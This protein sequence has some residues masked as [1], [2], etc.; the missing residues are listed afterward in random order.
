MSI[1]RSFAVFPA[2]WLLAT[3]YWLLFFLPQASSSELRTL[4]GKVLT[5]ELVGLT[6]KEVVL[7]GASGRSTTP[8]NE[9]LLVDLQREM[10]PPSGKYSDVELIDGSLFH[11]SRLNIKGSQVELKFGTPELTVTLPLAAVAYVLNS[12]DDSSS[13]PDWD[14]LIAKKSSQ[15]VL[16]IKR[17]GVLNGVEGTLGEVN[18]KGEI[19]FEYQVGEARKSRPMD[20][21]RIH[22]MIFQRSPSPDPP[23]PLC[24][25]QDVNQNLLIAAKIELADQTL[26]V[27]LVS[28]PKIRLPRAS[29]SRLDFNNDKVVF[30][31]DLKPVE[32]IEKS[33]QGRKEGPR[34]DKNL[35][36]GTMQIEGQTYPKGLAVHAHTELTYA[37]E[38]KYRRLEAVVGMDDTVGGN[39]NPV[40]KIEG[41][42]KELFSTTV[43]RSGK[44]R[45]L[46]IDVHGVRQ[47]RVVVTSSSLFD[48]GDHVDLANA[49]LSK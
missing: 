45:K 2:Y 24:K 14:K 31:S 23:P 6:N 13:R 26:A 17:E 18:E 49:K 4:S 7:A 34:M 36:N 30:L 35:E 20:L 47:L 33:R 32:V 46:D 29:L 40:V 22:G 11:C 42:G 37:I 27:S 15:D 12:A 21:S 38:G 41:D 8:I 48:F 25:I 39:G 9:V 10:A 3:G 43:T 28:G 19:A 1:V 16:V 5:G 44:S